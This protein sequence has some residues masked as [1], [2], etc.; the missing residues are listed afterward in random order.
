MLSL[1][2][3]EWMLMRLATMEPMT[4]IMEHHVL[5]TLVE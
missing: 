4:K 3:N 2:K 1:K 5:G